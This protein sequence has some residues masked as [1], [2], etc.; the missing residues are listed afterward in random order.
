MLL[1]NVTV[2]IDKAIEA[3]WLIWMRDKHIPVVLATG[4]FKG[5]KMYKVLHDQGEDTTSYS[6]QFFA[7]R[8][9]DVLAYLEKNAP[10]ITEIHRARFK[11]RHVVFQTLLEEVQ[12]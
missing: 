1:Y 2:G 7:E 6:V 11:D 12:A 8:I 9:E 3:E 10:A 4:Y 5:Y